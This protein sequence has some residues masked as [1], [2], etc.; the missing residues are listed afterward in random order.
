M[1]VSIAWLISLSESSS[2]QTHAATFS[3]PT[4][5]AV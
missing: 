5:T 4:G 3:R 2:T 1:I